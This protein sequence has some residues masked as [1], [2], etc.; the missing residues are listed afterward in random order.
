MLLLPSDADF[1]SDVGRA[2]G[3]VEE[4]R[5]E[6]EAIQQEEKDRHRKQHESFSR[7]VEEAKAKRAQQE[8]SQVEEAETRE[9]AADIV[10]LTFVT[11]GAVDAHKQ[12]LEDGEDSFIIRE[13]G[14]ATTSSSGVGV[15][16][17][18]GMSNHADSGPKIV[19]VSVEDAET[20]DPSSS[21]QTRLEE[22]DQQ[23]RTMEREVQ[24][25]APS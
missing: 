10:D 2:R 18:P 9:G 22:Y 1:A 6:R 16:A 7:M 20:Q 12:G 13:S 23:L 17:G 24:E 3:G 21:L 8:R 19:E 5:M 15:S 14:G 4:E 11:N 25:T